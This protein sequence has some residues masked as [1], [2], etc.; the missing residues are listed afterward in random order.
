MVG[1]KNRISCIKDVKII[2]READTIYSALS[3]KIA[4]CGAVESLSGFRSDRAGVIIGRKKKLP[5]N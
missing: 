2:D 3:N 4:K 5:Q 1:G